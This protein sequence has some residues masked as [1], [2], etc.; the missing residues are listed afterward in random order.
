MD[1]KIDRLL[2]IAIGI[3]KYQL[4]G[5]FFALME[6]VVRWLVKTVNLVETL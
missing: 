5:S 4:T 2:R 6:N 1:I 3:V